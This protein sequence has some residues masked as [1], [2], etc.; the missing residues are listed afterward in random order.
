M[1]NIYIPKLYKW[2]DEGNNRST[3]EISKSDLHHTIECIQKGTVI[4]KYLIDYHTDNTKG[5]NNI[6][7]N[8]PLHINPYD[9]K[10]GNNAAVIY[11]LVVNP[12][13][14]SKFQNTPWFFLKNYL[15]IPLPDF[16]VCPNLKV[17]GHSKN[18]S[19]YFCSLFTFLRIFFWPRRNEIDNTKEMSPFIRV[20]HKEREKGY[21]IYQTPTIMAVLDFKWSSARRYFIPAF[22]HHDDL[23]GLK[24]SFELKLLMA[25][26]A[27]IMWLELGHFI[28]IITSILNTIWP[29]F[30]FMLIAILEFGNAI[31][32]FDKANKESRIAEHKYYAEL[33]AEC[34]ALE[35]PFDSENLAEITDFDSSSTMDLDSIEPNTTK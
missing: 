29:F 25:F 3:T 10:K 32:A 27:L 12:R 16:T 26:T 6:A 5:Y 8:P 33:V 20:I 34:E 22:L 24:D 31:C 30:A 14:A 2:T 1:G 11:S 19:K 7:Y 21:K 9:Q 4:L 13:L 35:K 18:Y 23:L 17:K 15:K 28:Y